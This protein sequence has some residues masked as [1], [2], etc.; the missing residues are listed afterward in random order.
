M[1]WSHQGSARVRA[2]LDVLVLERREFVLPEERQ[3]VITLPL[4]Q[5]GSLDQAEQNA[6][7]L[8]LESL[9]HRQLADTVLI[10]KPR[11]AV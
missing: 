6:E 11:Q 2:D 1:R 9:H 5:S 4:C 8:L 3:K 10:E 7:I